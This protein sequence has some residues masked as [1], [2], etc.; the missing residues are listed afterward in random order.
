MSMGVRAYG[1]QGMVLIVAD[2][3]RERSGAETPGTRLPGERWKG[4]R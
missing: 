1:P 3:C 4:E 2:R